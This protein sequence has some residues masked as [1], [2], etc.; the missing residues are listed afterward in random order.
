[1]KASA[2]TPVSHHLFYLINIIFGVILDLQRSCKISA[3]FYI[4]LTVILYYFVLLSKL[5]NSHWYVSII[6]PQTLFECHP[7]FVGVLISAMIPS[8]VHTEFNCHVSPVLQQFFSL[9]LTWTVL[10]S[11][12]RYCEEYCGVST[13]RGCFDVLLIIRLV[14]TWVR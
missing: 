12:V 1:M 11:L 6:K 7:F 3:G 4:L 10:R 13:I 2:E 14:T 8:R 9:S 5:R